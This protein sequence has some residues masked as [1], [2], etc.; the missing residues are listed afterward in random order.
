MKQDFKNSP[1]RLKG[2]SHEQIFPLRRRFHRC[3][4]RQHPLHARETERRRRGR[5]RGIPRRDVTDD[6]MCRKKDHLPVFFPLFCEK[7]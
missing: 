6:R 5:E 2:H 7:R 3:H 4:A 1:Q